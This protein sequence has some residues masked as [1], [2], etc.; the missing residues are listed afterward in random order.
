MGAAPNPKPRQQIPCLPAAETPL[1]SI[2]F[3]PQLDG[4]NWMVGNQSW[5]SLLKPAC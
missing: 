4:E 1:G 3:I 5:K 2:P